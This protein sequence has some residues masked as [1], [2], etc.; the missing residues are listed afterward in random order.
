MFADVNGK[1]ILLWGRFRF[2]SAGGDIKMFKRSVKTIFFF[3]LLQV[4]ESLFPGNNPRKINS[5]T[6][7]EKKTT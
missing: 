1:D 2:P 5:M 3:F 7:G 4:E 6:G